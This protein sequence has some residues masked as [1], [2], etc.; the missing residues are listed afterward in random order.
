MDL[1]AYLKSLP[2]EDAREAFAAACGTSAGHMRNCVYVEGKQLAPATCVLVEKVTAGAVSRR[3]LR[4]DWAAIWP[5][6]AEA[7]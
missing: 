4:E 1:K 5:E 6:L 3:E 2:D 7:A